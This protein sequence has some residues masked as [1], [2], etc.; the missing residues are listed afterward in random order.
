VSK[1]IVLAMGTLL[2]ATVMWSQQH[3]SPTAPKPET[4]R[5]Q[6][7]TQPSTNDMFGD[8]YLLDTATG[9]VWRRISLKDADG[10]DNGLA[11]EPRVWIP[12]TRLDSARELDAF[13]QR[14]PEK[15][16]K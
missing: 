6:I 14:H 8:T 13:S 4:G 1:V 15:V 5:F 9:R 2:L 3:S 12:M 11:G 16:T 7:F 10:D